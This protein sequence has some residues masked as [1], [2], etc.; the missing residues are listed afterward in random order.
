M[1]FKLDEIAIIHHTDCV[2]LSFTD[3]QM[4]EGLKA[5]VDA[6]HWAEVD[7]IEFCANTG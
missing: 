2:M 3:E 7:K 5:R 1:L 4:R 6:A